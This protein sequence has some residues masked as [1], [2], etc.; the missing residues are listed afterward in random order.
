MCRLYRNSGNLKN[1]VSRGTLQARTG[2]D[3]PKS[4]KI[5]LAQRQFSG[6]FIQSTFY[7]K[8]TQGISWLKYYWVLKK[9]GAQCRLLVSVFNRTS[10]KMSYILICSCFIK[11]GD[12]YSNDPLPETL[13][14]IP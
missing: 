6:T 9:L 12:G 8:G 14:L 10:K 7:C 5:F 13:L 1:L 4:S 2:I 11:L 3:L